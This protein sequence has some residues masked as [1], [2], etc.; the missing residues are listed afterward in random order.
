MVNR[1]AFAVVLGVF[2]A[3][4]VHTVNAAK[5]GGPAPVFTATDNQGKTHTLSDYKGKFVVLEWHNEGCPYVKKHYGSGNM[6]AL[7]KEWTGKGVVWLSVISSGP[8]QQGHMSGEQSQDY[9]RAQ[10]ASPTAVLLDASGDLG[11]AYGAKTSP[12]MFVIDPDGRCHL[13]RG[14]RQPADAGS[15]QPRVREE[16]RVG[17]A[18]RGDEPHAG[19]DGQHAAVRLLGQ[20]REVGPASLGAGAQRGATAARLSQTEVRDSGSS[21]WR[22]AVGGRAASE[23]AASRGPENDARVRGFPRRRA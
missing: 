5:V 4:A 17:G 20:V 6:Q 15:G 13:Q 14:D 12:H 7:Q 9:V 3:A 8:G 10:Q 1:I 11:R 16:L 22:G 18:H 19:D 21:V 2:V 23:Q